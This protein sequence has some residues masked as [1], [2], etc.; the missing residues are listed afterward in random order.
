MK[1]TMMNT[2]KRLKAMY[3]FDKSSYSNDKRIAMRVAR[4]WIHEYPPGT[5]VDYVAQEIM[6]CWGRTKEE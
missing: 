6:A 4:Q 2:I 3:R 5:S 1:R